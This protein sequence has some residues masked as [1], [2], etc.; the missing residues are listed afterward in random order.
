MTN[1]RMCSSAGNKQGSG[2]E[3]RKRRGEWRETGGSRR[4]KE[5]KGGVWEG[6]K[7]GRKEEEKDEEE[8]GLKREGQR[9]REIVSLCIARGKPAGMLASFSTLEEPATPKSRCLCQ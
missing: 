5:R 7:E 4:E 9:G 1:I 8:R 6:R 2:G 3:K